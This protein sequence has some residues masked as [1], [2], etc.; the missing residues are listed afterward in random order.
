MSYFNQASIKEK[1]ISHPVKF[2]PSCGE[3]LRDAKSLLN[4]FTKGEEFVYF[5]WCRHCLWQGE[6]MAVKRVTATELA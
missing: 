2:C 5:C 4:V 1:D 6:I 3:S